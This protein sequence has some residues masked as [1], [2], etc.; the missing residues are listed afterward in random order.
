MRRF[1]TKGVTFKFTSYPLQPLFL[2]VVKTL[3]YAKKHVIPCR[4]MSFGIIDKNEKV[5]GVR[6][7]ASWDILNTQ[8]ILS[9]HSL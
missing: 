4:R 8:H 2:S 7:G 5:N 1:T 3:S 9:Y 6:L